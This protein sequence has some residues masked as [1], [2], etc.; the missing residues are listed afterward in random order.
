[1][2]L[3]AK[4]KSTVGV[5]PSCLLKISFKDHQD[6]ILN[7]PHFLS[8]VPIGAW[9]SLLI[10]GTIKMEGRKIRDTRALLLLPSLSLHSIGRVLPVSSF[11]PE[12]G[13][14]ARRTSARVAQPAF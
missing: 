3:S 6:A 5:G 2:F 11:M 14:V 9:R 10:R 4:I 7:R 8:R 13:A 12:R 1:M